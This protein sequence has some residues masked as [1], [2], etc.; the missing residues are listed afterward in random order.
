MTFSTVKGLAELWREALCGLAGYAVC[1]CHGVSLSLFA[2][3]VKAR[4]SLRQ[5]DGRGLL[6]PSPSPLSPAKLL[7]VLALL[8]SSA[9]GRSSPNLSVK[10]LADIRAM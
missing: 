8:V 3:Q 5:S 6:S 10:R 4:R 7:S 2:D 1:V 9:N